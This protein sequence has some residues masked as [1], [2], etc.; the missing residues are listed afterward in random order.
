MTKATASNNVV[1]S[2]D[3]TVKLGRK[4]YTVRDLIDHTVKQYDALHL[5]QNEQLTLYKGIGE[6]LLQIKSLCNGSRKGFGDFV[7]MTDLSVMSYQDRHDA[8]F[9]AENWTKVQKLNT[10]GKLDTLGVSAIRKR[11]QAAEKPKAPNSA[12]NVSKGKAAA[13]GQAK[14]EAMTEAELAKQVYDQIKTYGLNMSTFAKALTE[15][16]IKAS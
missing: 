5:L 2:L 16:H 13:K 1:V 6:A 7:K 14:P 8:M 4:S 3:H 15:L 10:N 11:V 12:G 9:I